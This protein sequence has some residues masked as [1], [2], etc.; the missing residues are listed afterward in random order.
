MPVP[1]EVTTV[2][3][4]DVPVITA[5]L[6]GVIDV[7]VSAGALTVVAALVL[8][9]VVVLSLTETLKAYVPATVGV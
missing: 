5:A 7:I 3:V 1:P 6:L 8:L 2:H 9:R 4:S